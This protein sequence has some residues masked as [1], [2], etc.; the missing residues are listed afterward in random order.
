MLAK[1]WS[2]HSERMKAKASVCHPQWAD[3]DMDNIDDEVTNRTSVS[4]SK[5]GLLLLHIM[6]GEHHS[7]LALAIALLILYGGLVAYDGESHSD[8]E[9]NS[10][11]ASKRQGKRRH[12][13]VFTF[14][15]SSQFPSSRMV[16]LFRLG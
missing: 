2:D 7:S 1:V 6:R 9:H 14:S 4:D 11:S 15:C 12:V 10:K 3:N 13:R 5:F 8:T 16:P